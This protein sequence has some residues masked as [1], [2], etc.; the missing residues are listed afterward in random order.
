MANSASKTSN[1]TRYRRISCCMWGDD[2]FRQL[3]KPQPNAQ[4]LW[5]FLLTGPQTQLVPGLSPVG[6][7][8]LAEMLDWPLEEFR[9]VWMELEQQH[10]AQADWRARLV[11]IPNAVHHNPPASPNVVRRWRAALDEM[12]EC[13]LKKNARSSL[14]TFCQ[15]LGLPFL[16]AF[17]NADVELNVKDSMKA[18]GKPWPNQEQD[19][20]QDQDQQQQPQLPWADTSSAH[21]ER[22]L[23]DG[24]EV[25]RQR[26]AGFWSVYPRHEGRESAWAAWLFVSPTMAH[27]AE[28]VAAANAY[29]ASDGVQRSLD[30]GEPQY[31][32]LASNWLRECRWIDA[33]G[34][35]Q[36]LQAPCRHHHEPPCAD[37]VQCTT[38]YLAELRSEG[39]QAVAG[40]HDRL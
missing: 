33:P 24:I 35:R 10:M 14:A 17:D 34:D 39:E 31:I 29:A 26:F 11:W 4:S 6:E 28:I 30:R 15:T 38:R 13:N 9:K 25:Q 20:D 3:T 27:A 37:E 19:Q 7:A 18:S 8:A 22:G 21:T 1:R 40:P 2:R 5:I 32:K 36:S 23:D 16:R 12:P